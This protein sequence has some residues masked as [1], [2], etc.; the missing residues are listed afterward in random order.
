MLM[1]KFECPGHPGN[2]QPLECR[3]FKWPVPGFKPK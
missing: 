2:K 3:G 1:L